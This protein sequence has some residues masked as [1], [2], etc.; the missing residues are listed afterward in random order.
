MS[1]LHND[2]R[3]Q[4]LGPMA[5]FSVSHTAFVNF[6]IYNRVLPTCQA[7]LHVK[8]PKNGLFLNSNRLCRFATTLEDCA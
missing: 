6:F 2:F 7:K 1:L 5:Q 8:T 3:I 4:P